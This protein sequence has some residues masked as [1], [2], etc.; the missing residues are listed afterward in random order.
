MAGSGCHGK[1]RLGSGVAMVQAAVVGEGELMP[2]SVDVV[3]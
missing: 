1:G 2:L 3:G